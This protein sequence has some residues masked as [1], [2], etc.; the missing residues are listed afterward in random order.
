MITYKIFCC[1]PVT[2]WREHCPCSVSAVQSK[3]PFAHKPDTKPTHHVPTSTFTLVG[4]TAPTPST[5]NLFLKT[6]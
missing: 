1:V 2:L 6:S 5:D 3:N 4:F